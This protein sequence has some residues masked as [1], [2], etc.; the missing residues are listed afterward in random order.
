MGRG[1]TFTTTNPPQAAQHAPSPAVNRHASTIGDPTMSTI[2]R[3][4]LA[5]GAFA[6][7]VFATTQ[8]AWSQDKGG[9]TL[10][11]IITVKDESVIGLS[12]EELTN[13]GGTDPATGPRA[14]S[15]KAG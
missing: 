7:L 1:R 9:I 6:A 11:K 4:A 10:F 2:S 5:C 3:R 14:L 12:A 15:G 13:P 8:P